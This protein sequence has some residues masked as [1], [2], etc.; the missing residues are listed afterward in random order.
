MVN[1]AFFANVTQAASM[2][3][4]FSCMEACHASTL[5]VFQCTV[6][7][8]SLKMVLRA[9]HMTIVHAPSLLLPHNFTSACAVFPQSES[10]SRVSL[11]SAASVA[12]TWCPM[13]A[14][15]PTPPFARP[16][17][18]PKPSN[19]QVGL[20]TGDERSGPCISVVGRG[21]L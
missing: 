9:A 1:C 7:L 14:R 13:V 4:R 6:S 5:D 11:G 15:G 17:P 10:Q 16:G 3:D 12:P 19:I 21:T 20:R 18:E 8:E 2:G